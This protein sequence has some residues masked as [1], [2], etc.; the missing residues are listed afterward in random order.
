[1][2]GKTEKFYKRKS[3]KRH[4]GNIWK[5][6]DTDY[7]TYR[8]RGFININFLDIII[9]ILGLGRKLSSFLGNPI[10]RERE[11]LSRK[12]Q[13]LTPCSDFIPIPVLN[14]PPC[15]PKEQTEFIRMHFK[16]PQHNRKAKLQEL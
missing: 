8:L 14:A 9:T 5:N 3:Y 4:L 11:T 16:T 12:K 1:M 6:L 7:V 13:E 15:V 2:G 10:K